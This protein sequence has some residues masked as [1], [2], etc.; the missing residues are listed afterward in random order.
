[1]AFLMNKK[2]D[3]K[4]TYFSQIVVVVLLSINEKGW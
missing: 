3:M 2:T 4:F 1:M